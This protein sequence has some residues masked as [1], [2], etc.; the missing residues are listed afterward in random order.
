VLTAALKVA[1]VLTA[2]L[3]VAVVLTAA[4][5]CNELVGHITLRNKTRNIFI[6]IIIR[7]Q[8]LYLARSPPHVLAGL[9]A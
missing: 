4:L 1:V 7:F 2:A 6:K 5:K 8:V 3:K 9:S